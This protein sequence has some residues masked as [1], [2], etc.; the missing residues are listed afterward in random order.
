[1]AQLNNDTPF[2][3]WILTPQETLQGSILT[4]TQKQC[5]QNQIAEL[6]T[7]RINLSFDPEHVLKFTQEE[8]ELKGQILA[9][10][11]LLILSASGEKEVLNLPS[12]D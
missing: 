8:A 2:T 11:Y 3:S 1:M 12:Q 7:K 6:A 9:L 5:I 10:Q 4:I